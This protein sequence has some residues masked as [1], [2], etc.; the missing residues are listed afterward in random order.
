MGRNV[1][2]KARVRDVDAIRSR[3]EATADGPLEL[4]DQEDIFFGCPHGRLKLRLFGDGRGELISYHRD[5]TAGPRESRF[6]RTPTQDPVS[7]QE[8]LAAVLGVLGVVRKRR[9]LYRAGPTRIHLDQVAGLG[10]FIEL[11]VVIADNQTVSE[12]EAIAHTLMAEL[13]I[14]REDLLPHAYIDLLLARESEA[15]TSLPAPDTAD[16]PAAAIEELVHRETRAWDMK[17]VDLLMTVFHPDMVWPWPPTP[18]AHDPLG[19][20]LEIGR[21]H[22]D[23][24]RD[25]WQALFDTH[26]LVHNRRT[27][28]R[29]EV[30]EQGDGGFAVV[31][32]D[33]L[34]RDRQGQD[35]QWIGRA[36]KI[37]TR[38]EAGWKMIAHTG[39]LEY[40]QGSDD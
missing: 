21:Y 15:S 3:I 35:F 34:W 33:T 27:L 11:E 14:L 16:D 38:T 25:G 30:S 36:C 40:P 2:I 26:Q 9:A 37:Y 13:G 28:R 10:D 6:A 12:G 23:R 32:V 29:V 5:D 39:L 18:S 1:E 22:H 24:W 17:D 7:L 8:T 19:W 20:V 4:L 31:D